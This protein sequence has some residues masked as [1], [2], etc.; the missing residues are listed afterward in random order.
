MTGM[1][2]HRIDGPSS[3][4]RYLPLLLG[5]SMGTSLAVWDPQVPALARDR[6]VIRWDLP[7]HGGSLADVVDTTPGATTIADLGRLVLALADSL[8]VDRFDYAGISVGG[9]VGAWLALHH[10]ERVASLAMVCSSARFGEPPAWHERAAL[11]RA[12]GTAPLVD[13]SATRWFTPSFPRSRAAALLDD[14]RAA[15]PAGYA[16][17]CDA[18]ASYDLRGDLA[19]IAVPTLV[20]AGRDDPATTPAHARELADGIPGASL[21][22]VA[23]AAHLA[24]VERPAPVLAAMLGHLASAAAEAPPRDDASRHAAGMAVRRAVLG[25][26]HV[27]RAVAG[28]TDFT[29]PFQDFITRYAWGEI[30]TR[31]GLSRRTR[32]CIT[33]TALVARGHHEELGLH[34]R[35]ALRNGLTPEEIREVLLQTAVYCGVPAANSAFAVADR[36]LSEEREG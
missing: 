14:L 21:V 15:D 24:N 30:W 5:P 23:R 32:S 36:I 18:L 3:E 2:H 11:V 27:D 17:G 19:R 33:L 12:E 29:A 9:G 34:V 7:G 35:A 20:I 4:D 1:L 13:M 22:E 10:P 28:A 25:D 6:R 16:A 31:P 8:G 26:R